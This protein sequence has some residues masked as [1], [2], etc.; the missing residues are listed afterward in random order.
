MGPIP[1]AA[2]RLQLPELALC[3]CILKVFSGLE[4]PIWRLSLP[5]CLL[6]LVGLKN[7][8]CISGVPAPAAASRAVSALA[9]ASPSHHLMP[10]STCMRPAAPH[11]DLSLRLQV[12]AGPPAR[13]SAM[14]ST[15]PSLKGV[16][17]R[18]SMEAVQATHVGS[19]F[20]LDRASKQAAAPE[21]VSLDVPDPTTHAGA[22]L[23]SGPALCSCPAVCA[24]GKGLPMCS[25]SRKACD[26]SISS[27]M[28]P[29]M[30]FACLLCLTC[31]L[32]LCT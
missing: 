2:Q 6:P 30:R 3:A 24:S 9:A 14:P 31:R 23:T 21:D 1:P 4:S 27:H 25:I 32:C 16:S 7:S 10:L 18:P 29:P 12:N 22:H 17:P 8:N 26:C 19:H 11:K 28:R 13:I 20:S 5:L 15:A